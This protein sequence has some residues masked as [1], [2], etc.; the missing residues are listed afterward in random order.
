MDTSP[1]IHLT[2]TGTGLHVRITDAALAVVDDE[3]RADYEFTVSDALRAAVNAWDER[4]YDD[5]AVHLGDATETLS[6]IQRMA[7]VCRDRAGYEAVTA[8]AREIVAAD[9]QDNGAAPEP[10]NGAVDDQHR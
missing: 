5:F 3:L 4:R 9:E 7:V 1:D 6:E 10:G 8:R 2:I